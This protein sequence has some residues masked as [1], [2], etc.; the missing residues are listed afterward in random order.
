[1]SKSAAQ[2]ISKATELGYSIETE[3]RDGMTTITARDNTDKVRIYADYI[4]RRFNSGYT[5]D[6]MGHTT[7][8]FAI[9]MLIH[10]AG[11]SIEN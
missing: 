10:F 4:G 8:H 5:V 6:R 2:I 9:W 11:D 1:M 3:T 7:H